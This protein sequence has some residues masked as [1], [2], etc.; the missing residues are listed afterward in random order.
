MNS[1]LER[2]SSSASN[3][4]RGPVPSEPARGTLPPPH[5]SPDSGFRAGSGLA[6]ESDFGSASDRQGEARRD[7][8][9]GFGGD[10]L[11]GPAGVPGVPGMPGVPG[12][13]G[14]PGMPGSAGVP[15]VPG[16]GGSAGS[17]GSVG[18]A[19]ENRSPVLPDEL[20]QTLAGLEPAGEAPTAAPAARG[21]AFTR[22]AAVWYG[23]WAGVALLILLIVFVAQNTTSVL[24]RF[25]WM[26]GRISLALA[27]LIAGVAGAGVAMAVAAA[28]LI[29]VRRAA[30]RKR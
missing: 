25:L 20:A 4:A 3:P 10:P 12:S 13:A 21:N 6:P 18:S 11:A 17:V 2:E 16:S 14:V 19:G 9:L 1:P 7:P 22:T 28:R 24:V 26:E 5:L 27:L 30:R 8:L 23:V 29:Q 15:G